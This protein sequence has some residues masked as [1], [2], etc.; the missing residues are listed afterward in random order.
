MEP[1][2][3]S[4]VVRGMCVV[5]ILQESFRI[6]HRACQQCDLDSLFPPNTEPG[7]S[8]Y[9]IVVSAPGQCLRAAV[10]CERVDGQRCYPININGIIAGQPNDIKETGSETVAS[11][12]LACSNDGTF[13]Q[14]Y[15]TRL[16]TGIT[17]IQCVYVGCIP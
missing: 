16:L 17:Q 11:S 6:L 3:N 13:S 15:G 12:T 14:K 8:A 4:I 2:A 1:I 9:S 7:T 10:V 5:H